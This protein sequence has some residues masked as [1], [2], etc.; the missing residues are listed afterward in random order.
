MLVMNLSNDGGCQIEGGDTVIETATVPGG[1]ERREGRGG[2]GVG[3]GIDTDM[4]AITGLAPRAEVGTET[5]TNLM[6]CCRALGSV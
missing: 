4:Q 2:K 6:T 3:A 5:V 1:D